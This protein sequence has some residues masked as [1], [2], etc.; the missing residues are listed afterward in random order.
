MWYNLSIINLNKMSELS[1]PTTLKKRYITVAMLNDKLKEL[2]NVTAEI[3]NDEIQRLEQLIPQ[4]LSDT[5]LQKLELLQASTEDKEPPIITQIPAKILV[6]GVE[7]D[8]TIQTLHEVIEL[9]HKSDEAIKRL[10]VRDEISSDILNTVWDSHLKAWSSA[11]LQDSK[12][13]SFTAQKEFQKAVMGEGSE[14]YA[15][16]YL[17]F[18]IN[19]IISRED[20]V[21]TGNFM[22]LNSQE[23]NGDSHQ[24]YTCGIGLEFGT[25][26]PEAH[27]IGGIGASFLLA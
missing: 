14:L 27:F 23:A 24:I 18:A 8:F 4:S 7:K 10:L 5:T 26:T 11:C 17:A 19:Y 13:K 21:F 1:L 2:P 16:G 12:A 22:R 25:W 3:P 6:D 15:D 20:L 9:A